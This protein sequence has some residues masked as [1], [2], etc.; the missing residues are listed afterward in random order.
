[1]NYANGRLLSMQYNNRMFLSRWELPNPGG[2]NN[3]SNAPG[4]T[5][6]YNQYDAAG[7]VLSDNYSTFTCDANRQLS[8]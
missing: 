5:Y 1:M 3:S 8:L 4:Y 6:S 2:G 7:N